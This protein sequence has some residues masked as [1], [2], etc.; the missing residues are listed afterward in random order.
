MGGSGSSSGKGGGGGKA[1][2]ASNAAR[3]V[4][5]IRDQYFS[6]GKRYSIGN[7]TRDQ[8]VREF[9]KGAKPGDSIQVTDIP[10]G[11]SD[12]MRL[13]Q[14]RVWRSS[15][16]PQGTI[17]NTS[18]TVRGVAQSFGGENTRIRYIRRRTH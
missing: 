4:S 1:S 14:D 8:S 11:E 7:S 9:V 12:F 6:Q 13:G 3:S 15:L 18:N 17:S 16:G 2:A 5:E 10:S